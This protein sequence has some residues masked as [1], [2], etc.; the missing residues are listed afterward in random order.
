[1]QK[2]IKNVEEAEATAVTTKEVLTDNKTDALIS[3][4]RN[5]MVSRKSRKLKIW[6]NL[7][8]VT[9]ATVAIV[10]EVEVAQTTTIKI[11]ITNQAKARVEIKDREVAEVIVTLIIM[12][13]LQ[14]EVGKIR[15]PIRLQQLMK[16][17][18]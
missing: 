2:G 5:E 10:V 9:A 7:S 17:K 14:L 18:I 11:Q 13:T 15:G 12:I 6:S 3:S 1:M 8:V 4:T 16:T